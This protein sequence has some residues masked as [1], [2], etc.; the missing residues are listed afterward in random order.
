MME[1]TLQEGATMKSV[2]FILCCLWLF[3]S[4]SYA[5]A[6]T[7]QVTSYPIDEIMDAPINYKQLAA[8]PEEI[9]AGHLNPPV[10]E[11]LGMSSNSATLP[12]N[13]SKDQT[14]QK[15][16]FPVDGHQHLRLIPIFKSDN[17]KISQVIGPDGFD[18]IGELQTIVSP[19]GNAYQ[20]ETP[21]IGYWH[22]TLERILSTNM[23]TGFLQ[24]STGSNPV[25]LYTY[26]DDID[27]LIDKPITLH[28]LTKLTIQNDASPTELLNSGTQLSTENLQPNI[29]EL[30]RANLTVITPSGH[31]T[32]YAMHSEKNDD[33]WQAQFTPTQAGLYRLHIE[34]HGFSSETGAPFIR[35]TQHLIPVIPQSLSFHRAEL[36]E[37]NYH[38]RELKL[39]ISVKPKKQL[40]QIPDRFIVSGQVWGT[41][42]TTQ[43]EQPVVWISSITE[44]ENHSQEWRLQQSIDPRWL[45]RTEAKAPYFIKHLQVKD[46]DTATSVIKIDSIAL[47]S[48][49]HSGASLKSTESNN[50]ISHDMLMAEKINRLQIV[51]GSLQSPFT[52]FNQPLVLKKLVLVHGYCSASVWPLKHFSSD[53]VAPI[54]PYKNHSIDQFARKLINSTQSYTSFGVIAHS[55]GGMATMHTL[56]YY[57]SGLDYALTHPSNHNRKLIQTI[58]SPFK[59]TALASNWALIGAMGGKGCGPNAD[60][61]LEG[62]AKWLSGIPMFI[63]KR[64]WYYT[65]SEQDL[66][67]EYNTCDIRS[68]ALLG[69]PDDGVVSKA[70]AQLIGGHDMGHTVGECHIAGMTNPQQTHNINRNYAMDAIAAR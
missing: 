15:I 12:V 36:N 40:N 38:R 21:E 31:K 65:T 63:R 22:V 16:S 60:L 69:D 9:L 10:P 48:F 70:H 26:F 28:A 39:D 27:F 11:L 13:F 37:S 49:N 14:Q 62:A 2:K 25:Q 17:Y 8:P 19:T 68:D 33:G 59:G 30:T 46:V 55:Q 4:M 57:M 58:G 24:V 1:M 32:N 67:G 45:S 44:L 47:P 18:Y 51:N 52:L 53:A 42:P 35:T 41:D 66:P 64:V 3:P 20:I 34:A 7:L 56:S 29:S 54:F 23:S 61:T 50:T 6:S 43:K 5:A